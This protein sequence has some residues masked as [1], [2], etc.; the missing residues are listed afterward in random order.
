MV[1]LDIGCVAYRRMWL[2]LEGWCVFYKLFATVMLVGVFLG[3]YYL[4]H[5]PQSP[6]IFAWAQRAYHQAAEVSDQLADAG[7]ATGSTVASDQD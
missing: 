4:G 5:K 6:D 3:G 1:Q 7:D 2:H